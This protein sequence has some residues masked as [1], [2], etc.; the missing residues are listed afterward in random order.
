MFGFNFNG[1]K[2]SV[3]LL[4]EILSAR[5]RRHGEK[6]RKL[7][8][9]REQAEIQHI[10]AQ[11]RVDMVRAQR[12]IVSAD[13]D[14]AQVELIRAQAMKT[15][16]EALRLRLENIKFISDLIEK[17]DNWLRSEQK[18]KIIIKILLEEE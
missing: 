18:T 9:A 15:R 17:D 5:R 1:D 12:E 11:T 7:E 4:S 3:E 14:N 13:L 8:I 6:K 2:E 16:E 10:N